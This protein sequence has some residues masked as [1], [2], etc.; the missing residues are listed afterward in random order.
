MF[1]RN[2][3]QFPFSVECFDNPLLITLNGTPETGHYFFLFC[4]CIC[5]HLFMHRWMWKPGNEPE[6]FTQKQC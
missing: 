5:S 6:I 4:L 2:F 1:H 3:L